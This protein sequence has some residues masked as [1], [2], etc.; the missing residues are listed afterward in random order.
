MICVQF[1]L[2]FSSISN[3]NFMPSLLK[4]LLLG[5]MVDK[6][7]KILIKTSNDVEKIKPDIQNT[8]AP[9][10]DDHIILYV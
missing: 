2:K 9:R 6:P 1:N 5:S 10:I 3:L 7:F 4:L 8:E